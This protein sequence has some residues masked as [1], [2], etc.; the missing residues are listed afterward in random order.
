MLSHE[1]GVYMKIKSILSLSIIVFLIGCQTS[2]RDVAEVTGA[3]DGVSTNDGAQGPNGGQ[4]G[5]QGE[6]RIVG[7]P[8]GST[9][10]VFVRDTTYPKLGEAYRDSKGL[11][12]GSVISNSMN[13][14]DAK[15]ACENIGARLPTL[16]EFKRLRNYLTDYGRV[17][18]NTTV[19]G[20][21]VLP[22]F[23]NDYFWSSTTEFGVHG[24]ALVGRDIG[25]HRPYS[26][27]AVRCVAN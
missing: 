3:N 21:E 9:G 17:K 11:I 16:E 22:G 14:Y 27:S 24:D 10:Q 13:Q 12:W 5:T 2:Q 23:S 4:R 15:K 26:V 19:D 25:Y 18:F 1:Q 20:K 6:E 7:Y 8:R